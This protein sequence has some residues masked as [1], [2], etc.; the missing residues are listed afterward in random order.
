MAGFFWNV[1]G[2]NKFL[3]HSVFKDWVT[4]SNMMFGCLLETSVKEKKA[5]KNFEF[6]V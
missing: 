4:R 6:S 5:G 3:K 1:R 2:F